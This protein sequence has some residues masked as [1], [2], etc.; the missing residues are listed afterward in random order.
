MTA[1]G[2]GKSRETF[3]VIVVGGGVAGLSAAYYLS[4]DSSLR[5][6]VVERGKI[7]QAASRA[8]AGMLAVQC[9]IERPGPFLTLALA[10][11]ALYESL[12]PRLY[13]E[14]GVDIGLRRS[15]ALR[16]ALTDEEAEELKRQA[17]E[18]RRW[19]LKA[20]WLDASEVR[21]LA[22]VLSPSG[23]GGV[24]VP[25]DG[26]VDNRSLVLALTAACARRGVRLMEHTEVT[27]WVTRRKDGQAAGEVIGVTTPAGELHAAAVVLAGG[28]WSGQL[29]AR[30]DVR[31][32][33]EP[34]RGEIAA[35]RVPDQ[36]LECI[37]FAKKACYLVPKPG[38]RLLVGA[39]QTRAGFR[40]LTTLGG[41]GSLAAAATAL[42]PSLAEA[43]VAEYWS[44]L[45]PGTPDGLPILGPVPGW[46]GL[47]L[48]TGHYRNGILLGPISGLTIAR[49]IR[50]EPVPVNWRPFGLEERFAGGG[51]SA[52]ALL[53]VV[54]KA[55]EFRRPAAGSERVAS[56]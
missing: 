44:G 13:D 32:P 31:L 1:A 48:T 53:P 36:P 42:A 46:S 39:T 8:A 27:G 15:G 37:V 34:V 23:R 14:T 41:L 22:P 25:D 33:V 12:A 4:E 11:R 50:K 49:L 40:D 55:E 52:D 26:H 28:A 45:R 16:V 3:D 17:E 24:F 47:Y 38:G 21:R 18:Q 20:Q 7:G 2:W 9:E 56:N 35:L 54:E 30:L 10:G 51:E 43:E 5:I 19:A 29:A 6:A